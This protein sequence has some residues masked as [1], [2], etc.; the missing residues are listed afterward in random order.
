MLTVTRR[1]AT[2]LKAAK[3]AEGA[4]EDTGIRLR[5][6]RMV[7]EPGKLAVGFAISPGPEPSD[8]QI[9]QDG[10]RIFVQD[11]LVEALDGRT[12]DIRDDAGEVELVFR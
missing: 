4:T 10:L 7:S 5:R 11:E 6:G 3:F 1:A 12:L 9:E 8:E 2:L